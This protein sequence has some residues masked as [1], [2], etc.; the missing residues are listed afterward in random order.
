MIISSSFNRL[1]LSILGNRTTE[2]G[3]REYN[4]LEKDLLSK[5]WKLFVLSKKLNGRS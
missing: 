2:V 5:G 1:I 3:R 4:I